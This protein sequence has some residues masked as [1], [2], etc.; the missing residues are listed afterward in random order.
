MKF[1]LLTCPALEGRGVAVGC[2]PQACDARL[3]RKQLSHFLIGK[4][5]L[6]LISCNGAR[7]HDGKVAVQHVQE[8]RHFIDGALANEL[9]DLGNARVIVD[10]TL[11]FP[12]M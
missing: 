12:L 2:L 11:D 8:L 4:V 5:L 3:N 6:K 1:D 7:S 10:L 9:A